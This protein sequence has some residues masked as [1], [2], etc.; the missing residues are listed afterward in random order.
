MGPFYQERHPPPDSQEPRGAPATQLKICTGRK[1]ESHQGNRPDVPP[2]TEGGGGGGGYWSPDVQT[3]LGDGRRPRGTERRRIADEGQTEAMLRCQ[4]KG[5]KMTDKEVGGAR[6]AS[7]SADPCCRGGLA[8]AP[9]PRHQNVPEGLFSWLGC[10]NPSSGLGGSFPP[11]PGVTTDVMVMSG[12]CSDVQA[13]LRHSGVQHHWGDTVRRPT[14]DAPSPRAW[15]WLM[16]RV[17]N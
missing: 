11:V 15:A 10:Q 14:P 1:G 6:R 2:V 12:P 3:A 8:E 16:T 7:G 5:S 17:S 13:V 9:G 4:L